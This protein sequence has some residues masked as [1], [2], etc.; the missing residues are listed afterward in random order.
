MTNRA[1]LTLKDRMDRIRQIGADIESLNA[2][3]IRQY[4]A[5][6]LEAA[7]R[8]AVW[9]IDLDIERDALLET[10]TRTQ[11]RYAAKHITKEEE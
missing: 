6:D 10:M 1:S 3:W 8:Y 7:K 5:G 11:R 9:A 2:E 4:E